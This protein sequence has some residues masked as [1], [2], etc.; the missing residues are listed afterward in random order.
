[1]TK[2]VL[3]GKGIPSWSKTNPQHFV[4]SEL[5]NG[6]IIILEPNDDKPTKSQPDEGVIHKTKYRIDFRGDGILI[7]FIFCLVRARSKVHP[8]TNN[9]MWEFNDDKLKDKD[10]TYIDNNK[11]KYD[12]M[13]DVENEQTKDIIYKNMNKCVSTM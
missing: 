12:A 6:S 2:V 4:E 8:K 5:D 7:A 1:M 9:W 11:S 13:K 3:G 10:R